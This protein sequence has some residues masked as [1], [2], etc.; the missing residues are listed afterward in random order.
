MILV[1]ARPGIAQDEKADL[2]RSLS[3][4]NQEARA[5]A[6]RDLAKMGTDGPQG[7]NDFD[8]NIKVG[9]PQS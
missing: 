4:K 7:V 2:I 3:D 1:F 6:A 5:A 8:S 9:C